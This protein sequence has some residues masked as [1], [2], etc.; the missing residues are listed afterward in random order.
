MSMTS[1]PPGSYFWCSC[2]VFGVWSLGIPTNLYEFTVHDTYS[3]A[4]YIVYILQILPSLYT[5]N[6]EANKTKSPF[7]IWILILLFTIQE[8]RH[9]IHHDSI[10]RQ[11][12]KLYINRIQIQIQKWYPI[13]GFVWKLWFECPLETNLCRSVLTFGCTRANAKWGVWKTFPCLNKNTKKVI[14]YQLFW[15]KDKTIYIVYIIIIISIS[16]ITASCSNFVV[17]SLL[18]IL[19]VW[20]LWSFVID[21]SLCMTFEVWAVIPIPLP[22]PISIW[23]QTLIW[24]FRSFC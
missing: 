14:N 11:I 13:F 23:I 7:E 16:I 5:E 22:I 12:C 3:K 1:M 10:R 20:S 6:V 19:V 18:F 9:Y 21:S 15:T 8:K 4:T 2:L 24:S 17:H